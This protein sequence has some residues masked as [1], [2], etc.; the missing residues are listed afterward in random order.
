MEFANLIIPQEHQ[1][2]SHKINISHYILLIN[3]LWN[4]YEFP[5]SSLGPH[6][7]MPSWMLES[8]TSVTRQCSDVLWQQPGSHLV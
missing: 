1:A 3:L 7:V 4:K 6:S 8:A 2:E 5:V